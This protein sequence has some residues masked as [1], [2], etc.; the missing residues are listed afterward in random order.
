MAGHFHIA[1][2]ALAAVVLS[3]TG[4]GALYT[5]MGHFGRAAIT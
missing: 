4:A 2:A 3:V 1:F 5:D